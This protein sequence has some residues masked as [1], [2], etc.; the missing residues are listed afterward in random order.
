MLLSL[1]T[2]VRDAARHRSTPG[3]VTPSADD[4]LTGRESRAVSVD[5]ARDCISGSSRTPPRRGDECRGLLC[6][7]RPWCSSWLFIVS[8]WYWCCCFPAASDGAVDPFRRKD[9]FLRLRLTPGLDLGSDLLLSPE[10]D[11]RRRSSPTSTDTGLCWCCMLQAPLLLLL[12][13]QL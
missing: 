1:V 6:S 4:L 13:N 2:Y 12:W 9:Q 10:V 3:S 11:G 5:H 8:R 7:A